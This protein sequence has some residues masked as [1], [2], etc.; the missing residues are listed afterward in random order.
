MLMQFEGV[1][2]TEIT[3]SSALHHMSILHHDNGQYNWKVKSRSS[4]CWQVLFSLPN[5]YMSYYRH[6]WAKKIN[7]L[8]KIEVSCDL[9]IDVT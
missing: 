5:M 8:A 4:D 9:N 3:T 6:F 2:Q 1:K 7:G